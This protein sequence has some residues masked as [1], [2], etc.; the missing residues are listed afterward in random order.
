VIDAGSV[1]VGLIL[2]RLEFE[3]S[4]VDPDVE[5]FKAEIVFILHCSHDF[6]VFV[7]LL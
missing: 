7:L 4:A 5:F 3:A 1:T 6:L 2:L